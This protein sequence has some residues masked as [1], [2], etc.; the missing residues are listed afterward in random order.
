MGDL[1]LPDA[2]V[3]RVY[4]LVQTQL[5]LLK[6]H[7]LG[8]KLVDSFANAAERRLK[9]DEVALVGDPV[10]LGFDVINLDLF[11]FS[12]DAIALRL[13]RPLVFINI[14]VL[15]QLGISLVLL[16]DLLLLLRNVRVFLLD[17]VL[18]LF[19]LLLL[20]LKLLHQL[21]QLLLQLAVLVVRVHVVNLN[22]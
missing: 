21:V 12:F 18:K 17:V 14:S 8:L 2:L 13:I 5:L 15:S 4:L 7:L 6:N 3:V 10:P 19:L 16:V 11:N 20:S 22:S 1:E 9:V